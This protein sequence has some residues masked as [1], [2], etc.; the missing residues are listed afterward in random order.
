[1]LQ[2]NSPCIADG[3]AMQWSNAGHDY[4]ITGIG[5]GYAA[6]LA[7][8]SSAVNKNNI[9]KPKE[10][11]DGDIF[12]FSYFFD[13]A[14]DAGLID[15]ENGGR[16]KVQS[17][18]NAAEKACGGAASDDWQCADLCLISALLNAFGLSEDQ[19][20]QISKKINGAETQWTL[21]DSFHLM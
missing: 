5:G 9:D 18:L 21:G 15:K 6:C 1:M 11:G 13:K 16:F 12:A 17:F 14:V 10:I 19:N 7:V 20:L 8:A 4:E 3:K 2:T